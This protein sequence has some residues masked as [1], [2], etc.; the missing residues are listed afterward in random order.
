MV[1]GRCPWPPVDRARADRARWRHNGRDDAS[2]DC[3]RRSRRD[4]RGLAELVRQPRPGPGRLI[5]RVAVAG[6]PPPVRSGR[7]EWIGLAVLALP[8]LL[9]TM[10]MS[11]LFLA[12]PK[13]TRALSPSSGEL[14]WITTSMASS[15]P[16]R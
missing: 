1:V 11:V 15:S 8:T 5:D 13:L 4:D 12:V 6:Q 7:Q 2:W 16:A 3:R 10:D 14:L 9:V